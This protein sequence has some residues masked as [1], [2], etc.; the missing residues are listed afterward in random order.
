MIVKMFSLYDSKTLVFGQPVFSPTAMSA[1][2][3]FEDGCKKDPILQ[4][5]PGDYQLYEIG[6]W[7]DA[8][9]VITPLSPVKLL[10]NGLDFGGV[11]DVPVKAVWP[12]T[13]SVPEAVSNGGTR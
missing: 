9:A 10:C 11:P 8:T 7:D 4:A 5:H 13:G 2:R 1:M 6:M 12:A 3:A